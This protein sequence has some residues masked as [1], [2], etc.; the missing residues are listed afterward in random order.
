MEAGVEAPADTVEG[1][2]VDEE[3]PDGLLPEYDLVLFG[4]GLVE[5]IVACAAARAGKSVLHLDKYNNY[6]RECNGLSL[7]Q[8]LRRARENVKGQYALDVE[9]TPCA[10]KHEAAPPFSVDLPFDIQASRQCHERVLDF[11][12]IS[13]GED[14]GTRNSHPCTLNYVMEKEDVDSS[15]SSPLNCH[16]AFF[17]YV[18]DKRMTKTRALA[19]SRNFNIDSSCRLLLGSSASIDSLIASGVSKYLEF[20]SIECIY[21][22]EGGECSTVPCSKGDIFTSK[23]INAL[24]KRALMKFLQIAIDWGQKKIEGNAPE[25]LNERELAAGRALKRPQNKKESSASSSTDSNNDG[26]DEMQDFR[27]YLKTE[28]VPTRLQDIIIFALCLHGSNGVGDDGSTSKLSTKDG[29]TFL[30]QHIGAL[31]RFGETAFLTSLYGS[32]EFPQSFCRMCAVWGGTY[33]LRRS[34]DSLLVSKTKSSG[35]SREM[36]SDDSKFVSAIRDS[37]GRIIRCKALVCNIEDWPLKKTT[38]PF[39]HFTVTRVC[40]VDAPLLPHSLSIAIIPP[41]TAAIGN[42]EPV[43]VV[44]HDSSA[45]VAPDGAFIVHLTTRVCVKAT[46][47]SPP[48]GDPWLQTLDQDADFRAQSSAL[49]NAVVAFFH[50]KVKFAELCY[51]TSVCPLRTL[52]TVDG[53]DELDNVAVCG[54]TSPNIHSNN[55]FQQA[56]V[57]FKRLFP[58]EVFLPV[59]VDTEVIEGDRTG[60][61]QDDDLD[62]LSAALGN[63]S[64]Q[65]EN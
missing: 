8:F 14:S 2:E 44:Q 42:S 36:E 64:H 28:K 3:D 59:P 10:R 56:Q 29:L 61:E 11:S 33:V 5:A 24:E 39:Y 58:T 62:A 13:P 51:A 1:P 19:K 18:K 41:L 48:I 26:F 25:T 63:I 50:T 4:T 7:E 57:V 55:A 54:D 37:T 12:D 15:S 30:Y 38:Q 6:G 34:I 22:Y 46:L 21:Y 20:K 16:P 65:T 43:Y 49:M 52:A 45:A 60:I 40:V 47:A 17:Q 9:C 27:N 32:S 35:S 23:L 31:G 53:V